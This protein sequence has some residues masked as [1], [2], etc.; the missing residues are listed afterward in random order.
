MPTIRS[1]AVLNHD[2][3][4]VWHL[5]RDVGSVADWFPAMS[6]SE[7][8]SSGRLVTLADGTRLVED[9]V[10]LDDAMRRMQ[11]RIRGGD[12]A[13]DGHLGTVDVIDLKDGRSVLVYSSEVDPPEVAAAFDAAIGDAVAGLDAYLR[14]R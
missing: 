6:S 9:V 7:P 4:T 2:A 1:H 14:E 3:S 12:L 5:V 8:S 13:V 11:Y 10:T